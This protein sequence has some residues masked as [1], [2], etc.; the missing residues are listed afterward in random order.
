MINGNQVWCDGCP[1]QIDIPEDE[2]GQIHR[3]L[4]KQD[5][6]LNVDE[7]FCPECTEDIKLVQDRQG[8]QVIPFD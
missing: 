3:W 1:E 4:T 5:W 6:T 7:T 8:E 2:M